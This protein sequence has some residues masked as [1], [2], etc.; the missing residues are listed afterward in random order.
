MKQLFHKFAHLIV[1]LSASPQYF[2]CL[3]L[4]H[5]FYQQFAQVHLLKR[6]KTV[7]VEDFIRLQNIR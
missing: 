5:L 2:L 1:L 3:L 6:Q 7:T 4:Q